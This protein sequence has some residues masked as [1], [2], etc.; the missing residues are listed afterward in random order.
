MAKLMIKLIN[1]VADVINNDPDVRQRLKVVFLPDYK[2]R[3]GQRV[4][5]ATD[6]SEQIST[7]GKEASG[8]G[9]M[10]F[11]MNGALTIEMLGGANKFAP[12]LQ[13]ANIK[14]IF[15]LSTISNLYKTCLSMVE[16]T[17]N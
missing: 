14:S 5:P 11:S 9:N 7:A 15:A 4:Y 2:V 16:Y 17:C 3:F 8:T 13:A 1:S 12:L 10:K 6:L